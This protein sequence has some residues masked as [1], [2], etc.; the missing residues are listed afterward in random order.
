MHEFSDQ[1][2]TAAAADVARMGIRTASAGS[3]H[4]A[5]VML[6]FLGDVVAYALSMLSTDRDI[7]HAAACFA[8]YKAMVL[9]AVI[10]QDAL[11]FCRADETDPAPLAAPPPG[12]DGTTLGTRAFAPRP[13]YL[14]GPALPVCLVDATT[15]FCQTHQGIHVSEDAA[16][17]DLLRTE[18]LS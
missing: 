10:R 9:E 7:R 12:V 14:D 11:A 8:A 17:F 2:L 18:V 16:I 4:D 1:E 3:Q 13:V 15:L 6:G 5:H